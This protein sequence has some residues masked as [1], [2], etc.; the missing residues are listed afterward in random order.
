MGF[1]SWRRVARLAGALLGATSP[2]L[3]AVLLGVLA[4][5]LIA[6]GEGALFDGASTSTVAF[7]LFV[8]AAF[9][10]LCSVAVVELFKRL[11]GLRGLYQRRQIAIWLSERGG[12]K[13]R[14]HHL[15]SEAVLS[16]E[17]LV[18]ISSLKV[19]FGNHGDP[20]SRYVF[21]Q[22]RRRFYDLPM[23]LIIGQMH[24]A[25]DAALSEPYRHQEFLAALTGGP[26]A[27]EGKDGPD[28]S[29][30][31]VQAIRSGLDTMQVDVGEGWRAYVRVTAVWISGVVGLAF[32]DLTAS[33]TLDSGVLAL[34]ALVIGGFFAWV[35]RDLSAVVERWRS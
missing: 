19:E 13:F 3:A 26:V 21:H 5:L 6:A 25:L 9:S 1:L 17:R 31:L 7:N 11:F 18:G 22:R 4:G 30:L 16:F 20:L 2:T 15:Y 32:A 29:I 28:D 27:K 24:G 35:F 8:F 33:D 14:Q 23:E 34:T 12:N 10:G